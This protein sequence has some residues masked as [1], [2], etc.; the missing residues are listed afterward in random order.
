MNRLVPGLFI[1]ARLWDHSR[2]T[3]LCLIS[4]MYIAL[5]S[6]IELEYPVQTLNYFKLNVIDNYNTLIWSI[7]L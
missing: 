7:M 6:T 4:D 2:R 5:V 3:E 1:G